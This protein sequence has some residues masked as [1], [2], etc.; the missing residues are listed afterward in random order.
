L[1]D[2]AAAGQTVMHAHV[3]VIPRYVGDVPNPR[4]GVRHAVVGKGYY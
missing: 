1:N 4:G 3:H 2:G